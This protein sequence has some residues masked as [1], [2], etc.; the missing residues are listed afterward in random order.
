[1]STGGGSAPSDGDRR[2]VRL[3]S[4]VGLLVGFM[5]WNLL[6]FLTLRHEIPWPD[7]KGAPTFSHVQSLLPPLTDS[8]LLPLLLQRQVEIAATPAPGQAV[9]GVVDAEFK[10]V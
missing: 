5:V 7:T 8:E 10:E 6:L 2:Q 9:Y 1:M 3:R 4:W